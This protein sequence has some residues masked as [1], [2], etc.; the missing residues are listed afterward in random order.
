MLMGLWAYGL[1]AYGL[2]ACTQGF[3]P[4]KWHEFTIKAPLSESPEVQIFKQA[5]I[6]SKVGVHTG[7]AVQCSSAVQSSCTQT[8][9]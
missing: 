9:C 3:H 8:G 7:G 1:W 6:D 2:M 4:T 5:C